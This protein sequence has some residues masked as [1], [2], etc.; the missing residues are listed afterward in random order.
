MNTIEYIN[1]VK[2]KC[3]ITSDY[4]VAKELRVTKQSMSRYARGTGHFD[5][6]VCV[7]VA[8]ILGIHPGIVIIDMHKLRTSSPLQESI[9]GDIAKGFLSL[10]LPAKRTLV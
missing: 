9:W 5:D 7:R 8:E 6:D 2:E 3:H 4:A 10:L 1:A